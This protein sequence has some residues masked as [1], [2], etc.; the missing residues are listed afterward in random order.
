MTT[1]GLRQFLQG[2]F[3]WILTTIAVLLA[4]KCWRN[5][6]WLQLFSVIGFYAIIVSLTKG[7]QIL[8]AFGWF[9]KLFG[10]ETGL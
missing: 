7:Q 1:D 3:F 9:L 2:D 6:N 4:I 5:S 8:S 10:I